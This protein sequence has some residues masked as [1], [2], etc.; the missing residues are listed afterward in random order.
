MNGARWV[1]QHIL[2]SHPGA[3][4]KVYAVWYAM[5]PSDA[6]HRWRPDL[7]RDPRV[8]HWW[9][10]RRVVGTRLLKEIGP[11][12]SR[13]APGSKDFRDEVLWDAYLLF[14]PGARWTAVMPTPV[15]WGY[16]ILAAREALAKRVA[17]QLGRR[18]GR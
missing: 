18:A 7:L 3:P 9:D 2:D 13:R 5:Y 1:Q 12:Q 14:E 10:E 17:E 16:T 15:S 4:L 11:H 6:R 8:E